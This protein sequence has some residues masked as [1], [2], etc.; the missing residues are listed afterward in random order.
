MVS[1]GTPAIESSIAA[2][3]PVRSLPAKQWKTTPP[4]AAATVSKIGRNA[5]GPAVEHPQVPLEH[6]GRLAQPEHH[7]VVDERKVGGHRA[8]V[9]GAGVGRSLQF[10]VGAEG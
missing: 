1:S 8:G 7:R 4:S 2:T 9:V 3:R 10:P 6:P 5:S